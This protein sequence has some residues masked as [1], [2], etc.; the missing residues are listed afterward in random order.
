MSS[1]NSST[2]LFSQHEHV[3]RRSSKQTEPHL[4]LVPGRSGRRPALAALSV[5]VIV[6]SSALFALI[7]VHATH[8]VAAIGVVRNISQGETMKASDF[9]QVDVAFGT[10]I[11]IVPVS[12]AGAVFGKPAA[13]PLLAGA[14]LIPGDIGVSRPLSSKEAIVGVDLKPGMFPANGLNTGEHVLVVLTGPAGSPVSSGND[15]SDGNGQ[16]S[17]SPT[18]DTSQSSS[19]STVSNSPS[20]IAKAT[21][22]GVE[23]NPDDSGSGDLAAS[24][25][26]SSSVAPLIAD[27][28]VEGQVALVQIGGT[29]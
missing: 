28:S 25:D 11:D 24:L 19:G 7:Y 21:I 4:R 13:V 10:G 22:V 6:M 1:R 18:S 17:G 23:T 9:R 5:A 29:T 26:V 2:T 15:D 12:S 8:L 16:S 14:L 27:S 3:S 20:V